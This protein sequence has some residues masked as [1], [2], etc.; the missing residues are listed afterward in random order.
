MSYASL[1]SIAS[2]VPKNCIDNKYFEARLETTDEW[3][4][5]RTGIITRYFADPDEHSSDLGA[6]AAKVAIDRALQ[7]GYGLNSI[8]DI[9]LVLCATLSQDYSSMPSTAC[10]IANKLG[11]SDRPAFDITAACSGFIYLMSAAKAYI[12]SGAYKN[13]LIVGAEKVSSVLDFNDRGTCILFGDG[14]GAAVISATNNINESILDVSIN[15][16][17]KYEDLLF[18]PKGGYLHMQGSDIFKMAVRTLI[19]DV[20]TMLERNKM[21]ANDIDFFIPHQANLRIIKAVGDSIN[22]PKEKIVLTVQKYGN[23]SAASIPMAMNEIYEEGRLKTGD[24]MLLDAF[25]G[26]LTWGSALLHFNGA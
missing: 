6:K 3:I 21:S 8:S 2:Y 7:R 17:G 15:S 14:A 22:F 20:H 13:V 11:I 10:I 25:G 26:G 23:T 24:V 1:I 16:D 5:K 19:N 9:D 18:T 4:Q 12:E